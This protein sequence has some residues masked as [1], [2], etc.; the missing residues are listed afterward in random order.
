[1]KRK[2]RAQKRRFYVSAGRGKYLT[3]EQRLAEIERLAKHPYAKP[4]LVKP[5]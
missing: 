5:R 2:R 3:E 1:M 4:H